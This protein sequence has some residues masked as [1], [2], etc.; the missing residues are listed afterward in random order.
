M[1]IQGKL[2]LT[3]KINSLPNVQTVENGWQRFELDCDG[4]VVSVTVKPKTWKVRFVG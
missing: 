2:E 4:Q 3:I 1:P